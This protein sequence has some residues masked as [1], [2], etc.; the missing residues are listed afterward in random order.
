MMKC[1]WCHSLLGRNVALL[2]A[3]VIV[4]QISAVI[5]FI[6]F[7]Q[8]PHIAEAA[9]LM[10]SQVT[11]IDQLLQHV[12]ESQ[13]EQYVQ[14]FNGRDHAPPGAIP[15]AHTSLVSPIRGLEA[16]WFMNELIRSLPDDIELRIQSTTEHRLWAQVHI[17]DKQYWVSL[18]SLSG[19]PNTRYEGMSA[20]IALSVALASIATLAAYALHRRINR[21]LK[22]LVE[23]AQHLGDGGRPAPVP[24]EGPTEIATV[25]EAFNGM[26]RRLSDNEVARAM[27]LAGISHDI[28]TPLTKLRLAIAMND[29][30][31]TDLASAERFIDDIDMIV[32]QFI[33]FA[34]GTH[35]EEAVTGNLNELVEQLVADFAGLGHDF[36]RDLKPLPLVRY[37]PV[38]MLRLLMNLMHNAVTH[39]KTGLSV[40][41][42]QE[43][44]SACVGVTDEGPGVPGELLA[45]LVQP[46]KR[47][48]QYKGKAAGA[49]L[50]LAI[51]NQI[52]VQHGGKLTL[53]T[54]SEGGFEAVLELPL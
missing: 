13:R 32:G 53:A 49:G 54:R 46:F 15:V 27:M 48:P 18:S 19:V 10:A 25:A 29:K 50:G 17:A 26:I 20:A 24:V 16:R 1:A 33:D 8:K 11:T 38:G 7:V 31:G 39:G 22:H 6:L 44:R 23:A 51:A 37:G 52:A 3:L 30:G 35:D 2:V 41:T 4:S 28:R 21:P 34:R 9:S 14:W 42:W 40:R 36:H 45:H 47:G 43:G 12:P 5:V